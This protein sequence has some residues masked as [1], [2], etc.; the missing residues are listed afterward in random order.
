[1]GSVNNPDNISVLQSRLLWLECIGITG[2]EGS[3]SL[4]LKVQRHSAVYANA[5]LMHNS[6]DLHTSCC[7]VLQMYFQAFCPSWLKGLY[8]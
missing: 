3:N 2:R 1:M 4:E 6:L 8:F 7:I 5:L